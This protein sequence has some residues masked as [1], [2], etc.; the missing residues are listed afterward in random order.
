MIEKIEISKAILINIITLLVVLN[1]PIQIPISG[2]FPLLYG[3]RS[4][5]FWLPPASFVFPSIEFHQSWNGFH[6][7]GTNISWERFVVR[8]AAHGPVTQ[9]MP[10]SILQLRRTDFFIKEVLAEN[11]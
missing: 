10:A 4:L 5:F 1:P 7:A 8:L 11:V 6:V 3:P 2:T 9:N